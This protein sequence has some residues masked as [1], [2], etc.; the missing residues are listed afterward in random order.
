MYASPA[1]LLRRTGENLLLRSMD[2]HH[3]DSCGAWT[4]AR[5]SPAERGGPEEPFWRILGVPKGWVIREAAIPL[6]GAVSE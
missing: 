3:S 5:A 4:P 6:R 1:L 2:A